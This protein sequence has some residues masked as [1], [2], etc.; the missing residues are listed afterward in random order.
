MECGLTTS[1]DLTGILF[2]PSKFSSI[3]IY[4]CNVSEYIGIG[5]TTAYSLLHIKGNCPSL[6][7]MGQGNAGATASINLNTFDNG[8][9]AGSCSIIA[10]DTE[11]LETHLK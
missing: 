3:V 8:T 4:M 9:N 7:I 2:Q 6:T 1:F 5:T 10:T 11:V